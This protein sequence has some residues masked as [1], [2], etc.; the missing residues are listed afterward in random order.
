MKTIMITGASSNTGKTT[1]SL[2]LARALKNRGL[3]ISPFKTGPDFIDRK[4]LSAAAKKTAGNLDIHMMGKEGLQESLSMNLGEYALIEGAMGYFDGIY[5]TYE[6]SSFHISEELDI[7][8]VLVYRPKGEMFS[9]IPKI[10]GIVDFSKGR[11]KAIIFN[12]TS[13]RLYTMFKELVEKYLDIEILGYI[14]RDKELKIEERYL[15]LFQPEENKDLDKKLDAMANKM[16]ETLDID[17]FIRLF[18][19]INVDEYKYPK[20]RDVKIAIAYD[21]AFNFYYEENLKLLDNIGK[22]IYFSPLKDKALPKADLLYIGGGYPELYKEKLA[23]NK[24]MIKSIK[25]FGG[26]GGYIYGEG[27]GFMYLTDSIEDSSMVGLIPG[28]ANMTKRLQRFGYINI[29]LEE[30]C[31][32]GNTGDKVTGKEYHRSIVKTNEEEIYKITK[33]KSER[34][35][36]CG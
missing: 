10:K 33:P 24:S 19:D 25:E 13:E 6:N 11:I 29:E 30:D 21:K 3:D 8:A 7:P 18:K 28:Q 31:I 15:G 5:N 22:T 12:E 32:L 36:K 23:N 4:Y 16:E 27:G 2:G 34:S 35:W 20:K 9:A 14:P 26:N 17:K 1:L